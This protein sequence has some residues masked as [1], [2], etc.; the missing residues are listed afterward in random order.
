MLQTLKLMREIVLQSD[1]QLKDLIPIEDL[2]LL[3]NLIREEE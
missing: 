1:S 3:D 2:Q